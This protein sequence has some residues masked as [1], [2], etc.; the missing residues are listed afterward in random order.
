MK[1]RLLIADI[2]LFIIFVAVDQ[3]TKLLAAAWLK[4]SDSF[5]VMDG[6]LELRYLENRGAAFG[7]FKDQKW[8]FVFIAAVITIAIIYVLAQTP[9]DRKYIS[10]HMSL[11][12]IASGAIGNMADRVV[13]GYVRDFIYF[14]IIDFPI[15]NF[16]DICVTVGTVLMVVLLLFFY[17]ENDLSFLSFKPGIRKNL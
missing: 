2:I 1:K 13:L 8:F 11:T 3:Y 15:F 16:A 6:V 17:K 4:D 7:M 5:V 12:L 14:S 9:A 10:L